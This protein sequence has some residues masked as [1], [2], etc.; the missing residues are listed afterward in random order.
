MLQVLGRL[1]MLC[2][3]EVGIRAGQLESAYAAAQENSKFRRVGDEAATEFED[4][5]LRAIQVIF[6]AHQHRAAPEWLRR[7]A[8]RRRRDKPDEKPILETHSRRLRRAA[9][10]LRGEKL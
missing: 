5:C 2:G 10:H 1:E 3:W 6:A 7:A 4:W 9:G 8:A